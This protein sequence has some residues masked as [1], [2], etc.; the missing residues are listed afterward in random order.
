MP[1]PNGATMVHLVD[2]GRDVEEQRVNNSGKPSGPDY[3]FTKCVRLHPS[4]SGP[5]SVE[6]LDM[7]G[8]HAGFSTSH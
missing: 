1:V 6:P 4:L 3:H 7:E 2:D 8:L 5:V